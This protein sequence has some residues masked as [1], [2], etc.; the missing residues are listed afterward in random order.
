MRTYLQ[1]NK[2]IHLLIFQYDCFTFFI[3]FFSYPLLRCNCPC[4]EDVQEMAMDD[5]PE[6]N[7]Q[8]T[9]VYV[10]N[11]GPEVMIIRTYKLI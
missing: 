4:V 6:S 2:L 9:T 10:G 1:R 7:Q 3:S 8:Y 11:L 5:A